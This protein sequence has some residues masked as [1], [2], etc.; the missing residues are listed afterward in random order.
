MHGRVTQVLAEAGSAVQ[1]GALL[2]VMEAM[3]MEH[4]LV[5]PIPGRVRAVHARAGE[6]VA[7]RKLLVEIAPQTLET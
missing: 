3:K 5:A 1:A 7:A 6:Q 2:V 4:Q